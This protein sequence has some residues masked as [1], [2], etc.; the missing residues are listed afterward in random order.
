MNNERENRGM[1]RERIRRILKSSDRTD[2]VVRV[3]IA[4]LIVLMIFFTG[5]YLFA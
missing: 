3:L 4:V 2:V 1:V 5:Y